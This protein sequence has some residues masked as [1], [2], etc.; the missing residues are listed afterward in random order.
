[1]NKLLILLFLFSS[2]SM[3]GWVIELFFRRYLDPVESKK[4]KWVN[5]GFLV[6]PY[7][8]IYGTGLILLYLLGH[9]TIPSLSASHPI[10]EKLII[11]VIMAA[12]MT[13]IEFVTGMIFINHLHLQLWDYSSYWGNI[14]GVICPLFSMFWYALAAFYYLVLHPKVLGALDWLSRNLA[15]SFFIGFFYG[16]F[17]L[18]LVYSFQLVVKIKA[19]ADEY[20][21]VIKYNAYKSKLID[22]REEA[23]ERS[24]F[25]FYSHLSSLSPKEVFDRYRDNFS[26]KRL[27]TPIKKVAKKVRSKTSNQ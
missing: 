6:G 20:D 21:I 9:I 17:V 22:I 13:F 4:K 1:M 7:L 10:L 23:K 5:P 24:Y 14:K 3:T 16:V 27:M 25:F 2:G 12:C 26:R 19:L 8:P 15:F 11:F 18:D